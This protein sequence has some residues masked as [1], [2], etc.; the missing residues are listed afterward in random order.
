MPITEKYISLDG[1]GE[2]YTKLK[3]ELAKSTGSVLPVAYATAAGSATYDSAN[4]QI[5]TYYIHQIDF[6]PSGGDNTQPTALTPTNGAVT[7]DLSGYALKTEITAALH[8]KG[9]VA[10]QAALP[11]TAATAS[12]GDLYIVTTGPDAGET[13]V[14]Y[15]CTASTAGEGGAADT[16]TWEKLGPTKDFSGF[17]TKVSGATAGNLAG[18]DASGNLTDSGVAASKLAGTG[19]VADNDSNFVTGDTVY[20]YVNDSNH[21]LVNTIESITINGGSAL[22]P[23]ASKN[24]DIT[25]PVAASSIADGESGY[26]TGDQV[27]DYVANTANVT[28]V[29]DAST[30]PAHVDNLYEAT[31]TEIDALFV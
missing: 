1:L 9:V 11:S 4:N 30:T 8:F 7:I 16:V 6:T 31:A 12:V 18:L 20:D 28:K 17:A 29:F 10:T 19:A 14:E 24:V 3:G 27:Y 26:A 23:D 21:H 13:N 15:V 25:V 2:F 22:T 5:S